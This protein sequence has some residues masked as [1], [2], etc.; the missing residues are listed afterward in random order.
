MSKRNLKRM[1]VAVALAVPGL[2]AFACNVLNPVVCTL[3]Y[4]YGIYGTVTNNAGEAIPGITVTISSLNY[5]ETAS[6]FNGIQYVGAGEREGTYS[7]TAEAP[8]YQT[9]T[10]SG[11]VVT[12][13]ECHVTP[14]QTDI[15]LTKI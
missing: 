10:V 9:R 12:G 5:S 15:V 6:V 7:I 2:G 8:G 1:W 14:V 4:R 3:E 11:V 13:D